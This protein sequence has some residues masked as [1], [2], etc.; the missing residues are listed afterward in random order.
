M[1]RFGK[2]VKVPDA[3]IFRIGP[4]VLVVENIHSDLVT[5]CCGGR[6]ERSSDEGVAMDSGFR[7][8]NAGAM[9]D[10]T[11]RLTTNGD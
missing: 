9:N 6:N 4:E 8:S 10:A 7:T 11:K 5:E 3:N 1:P 2:L